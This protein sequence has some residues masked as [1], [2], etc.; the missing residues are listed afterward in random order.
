MND[1]QG[2][3]YSSFFIRHSSVSGE[4]QPSLSFSPEQPIY[5]YMGNANSRT[6]SSQAG[7]AVIN[8]QVLD[9]IRLLQG[10][11][12]PALLQTIIH[13]YLGHAPQLLAALHDAGAR[14]DALSLQRTA[15]SLKSSSM[16]LGATTLATLCQD[17]E[18]M[19]RQQTL[20]NV[21]TVLAAVTAEYDLVREALLGELQ[22]ET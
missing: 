3:Q 12:S 5:G 17:L 9:N 16:A 8:L 7:T 4:T 13:A 10:R 6:A 18:L 19:G 11:D 14:S 22:R 20:E 1:G 15:H 21:T 2:T